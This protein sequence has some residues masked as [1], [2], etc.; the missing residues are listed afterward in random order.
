[1]PDARPLVLSEVS[2]IVVPSIVKNAL[3]PPRYRAVTSSLPKA[4]VVLPVLVGLKRNVEEVTDYQPGSMAR[5][6]ARILPLF[7]SLRLLLFPSSAHRLRR[8]RLTNGSLY[9]VTST[10][11]EAELSP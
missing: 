4:T 1:M 7:Q 5:S 9:V 6:P 11:K 10:V 2:S 8:P 3:D